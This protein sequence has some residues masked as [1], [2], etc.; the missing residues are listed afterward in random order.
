MK[1]LLSWI[2]I[3]FL[4]LSFI[5][6][7]KDL[8]AKYLW[9]W[10]LPTISFVFLMC[11][12]FSLN[13]NTFQHAFT[14]ENFL[15]DDLNLAALISVLFLIFLRFFRSINSL[16]YMAL[17]I[18]TPLL[19]GLENYSMPTF[20]ILFSAILLI[21][22]IGKNPTGLHRFGVVLYLFSL[23]LIET[24]SF[25]M[26]SKN[27]ELL[28]WLKIFCIFLIKTLSR[29]NNDLNGLIQLI[30]LYLVL[31]EDVINGF[32]LI[33]VFLYSFLLFMHYAI[34]KTDKNINFFQ[35]TC[36]FGFLLVLVEGS[37]KVAISLFF[38]FLL[39]VSSLINKKIRIHQSQL[40]NYGLLSFNSILP[41]KIITLSFRE[42]YF[43]FILNTLSYFFLIIIF[44]RKISQ[45]EFVK[46]LYKDISNK[47]INY[48][49]IIYVIF[50][51]WEHS[52]LATRFLF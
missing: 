50:Y 40:V 19:Y 33:V 9:K 16:F 24:E 14:F 27:L 31:G 11:T 48:F 52:F 25:Y 51:Y 38:L 29:K 43:L 32:P 6:F 37:D 8:T 26:F 7:K 3:E 42:S 41:I 36:S 17:I 20:K 10:I 23:G 49:H 45:F 5:Y 46:K 34:S 18:I 30:L 47:Q 21:K 44:S 15:G 39:E 4:I 13:I 28:I 12:H 22:V 2:F 1:I 35:W